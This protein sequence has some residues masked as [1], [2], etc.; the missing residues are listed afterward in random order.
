MTFCSVYQRRVGGEHLDEEA[1]KTHLDAHGRTVPSSWPLAKA[2]C[3]FAA[4]ENE[5][6]EG[7]GWAAENQ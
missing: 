4:T 1:W 7:D 3:P 5:E 2:I 6:E